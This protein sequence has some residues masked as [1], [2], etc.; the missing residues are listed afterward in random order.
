MLAR[1]FLLTRCAVNNSIQSTKADTEQRPV[2]P[3]KFRIDEQK[4][5]NCTVKAGEAN[6]AANERFNPEVTKLLFSKF[7]DTV[8]QMVMSE[9]NPESEAPQASKSKMSA[10]L[11]HLF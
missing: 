10:E 3:I 6:Y 9:Q 5:P 7:I 2:I 11:N 4:E 1:A 8:K